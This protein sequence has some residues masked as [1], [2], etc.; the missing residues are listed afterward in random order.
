M[1]GFTFD[2]CD[3][4]LLTRCCTHD[5]ADWATCVENNRFLCLH[6]THIKMLRTFQ[7]AF[8]MHSES[9]LNGFV[10]LLAIAQNTYRFKDRGNARFV[11]ATQNRVAFGTDNAIFNHRL[12]ADTRF[13][14]IHVAT[15]Q[16]TVIECAF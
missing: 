5:S 2:L 16:N 9:N 4:F 15:K 8:F 1:S 7:T 3:D 13:N 6:L 14:R 12:N 10:R 11:I